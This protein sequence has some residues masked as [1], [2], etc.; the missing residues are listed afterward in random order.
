MRN[1]C[2]ITTYCFLG[3]HTGK[4][5]N[6]GGKHGKE[7]LLLYYT[8]LSFL[9]GERIKEIIETSK[10]LCMWLVFLQFL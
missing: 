2:S 6:K 5:V 1:Q 10:S 8:V 3:M 4:S 9:I 7:N